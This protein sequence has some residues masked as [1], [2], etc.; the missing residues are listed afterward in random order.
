MF[1]GLLNTL[2]ADMNVE[3]WSK[4]KPFGEL[5]ENIPVGISAQ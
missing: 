1:I 5:N 2:I 3:I 4:S